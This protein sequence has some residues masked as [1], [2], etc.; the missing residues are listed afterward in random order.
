MVLH[1]IPV[2]I[3]NLVMIFEY[4]LVFFGI[5]DYGPKV[6]KEKLPIQ[7][8][9]KDEKFFHCCVCDVKLFHDSKLNVER[10]FFGDKQLCGSCYQKMP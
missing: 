7:F 8:R 1:L 9:V 10:Y 2:I 3:N 6:N 4:G 5:I